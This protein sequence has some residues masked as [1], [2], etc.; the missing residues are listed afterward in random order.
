[1]KMTTYTQKPVFITKSGRALAVTPGT[2][3]PVTVEEM[4]KRRDTWYER[5]KKYLEGYSTDDFIAEK[6]SDVEKG[7]L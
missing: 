5:N 1:M 4:R 3:T 6:H 7:L 2:D